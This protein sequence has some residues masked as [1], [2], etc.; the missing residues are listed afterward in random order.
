MDLIKKTLPCW[1]NI[2]GRA[3]GVL[4]FFL[5]LEEVKGISCKEGE[6]EDTRPGEVV[7][8]GQIADDRDAKEDEQDEKPDSIPFT[9]CLDRLWHCF[10]PYV[11]VTLDVEC[12]FLFYV[13]V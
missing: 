5:L 1:I 9:D 7:V 2:H 10:D 8:F 6:Q 12:N 3:E 4:F 13:Q 11:L